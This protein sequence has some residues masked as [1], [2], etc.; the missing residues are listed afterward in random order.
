MVESTIPVGGGPNAEPHDLVEALYAL[1]A[2]VHRQTPREMSLTASATLTR[3]NDFGPARVTA[4]AELQGV[5]QPSMT[6]LVSSLEG[7]GLVTRRRD[8]ADGRAALVELT[9]AGRIAVS[10]RRHAQAERFAAGIARLPD[11]ERERLAAAVPALRLLDEIL[12]GE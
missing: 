5:T 3:L 6:S 2:Q 12:R 4:L 11:E 7:S 1:Y 8:P 9:E 10:R